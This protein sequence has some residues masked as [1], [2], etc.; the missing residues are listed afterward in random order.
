M[1]A[2]HPPFLF[3]VGDTDPGRDLLRRLFDG[4]PEVAVAPNY[5]FIYKLAPRRA[6]FEATG[7]REALARAISRDERFT[8]WGLDAG[9]L[10]E[11]LGPEPIDF[12]DAVRATYAHLAR[13]RHAR[14][15]AD[16]SNWTLRQVMA[17]AV[18]FGESRFVHVVEDPRTLCVR[19]AREG[20]SLAWVAD[21]WRS[22]V[23]LALD[24][25]AALPSDR[26]VKIMLEE[27]L[28]DPRGHAKTIAQTLGLGVDP[29]GFAEVSPEPARPVQPLIDEV[30][31]V[32][33]LTGPVMRKLGYTPRTNV[34]PLSY[35]QRTRL[36]GELQAGR[37]TGPGEP[38]GERLKRGLLRWPAIGRLARRMARMRRR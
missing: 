14:L 20:D 25:E 26:F 31:T 11:V 33:L 27:L 22:A 32:E 15:Y 16:C 12:S 8:P 10:A 36:I 9:A 6:E 1:T 19:R 35:D 18:L 4:H 2:S 21:R 29:S 17:H 28:E 38:L 7:G 34:H 3:I 13:A 24:A 5:P 37:R 30:R 23:E